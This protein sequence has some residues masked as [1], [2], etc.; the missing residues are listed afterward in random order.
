MSDPT[1]V[2]ELGIHLHVGE[3]L[4]ATLVTLR[5]AGTGPEPGRAYAVDNTLEVATGLDDELLPLALV[6]RALMYPVT[7]LCHGDRDAAHMMIGTCLNSTLTLTEALATL[8][9]D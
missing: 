6:R 5:Q 4:L 9:A 7:V 2:S 1:A 3:T 8:R